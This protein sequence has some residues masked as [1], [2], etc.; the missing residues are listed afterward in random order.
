[1]VDRLLPLGVFLIALLVLALGVWIAG[2]AA[3][4]GAL[5]SVGAMI[6]A[7]GAVW[8]VSKLL[9]EHAS[10]AFQAL[11]EEPNR[12]LAELMRGPDYKSQLGFLHAV[13]EDMRSVLDLICTDRR[14]LIVFIDDLDR[15]SP[16]V[17]AEVIQAINL[18]VA[19]TFPN[20]IFVVAMEPAVV[21]AHLESVYAELVERFA[22]DNSEPLGWLFLEKIVQLP[23][24]LPG[25]RELPQIRTYIN[26]L[27]SQEKTASEGPDAALVS[28]AGSGSGDAKPR[29]F[30]QVTPSEHVTDRK[31]EEIVGLIR[32]VNPA[33]GQIL[34]EAARIQHEVL[35]TVP[36]GT[37]HPLAAAAARRVFI[38]MFSDERQ[39]IQEV[40]MSG[41]NRLERATPR[42]IKR[43]IN[44]FRFFAFVAAEREFGGDRAVTLEQTAKLAALAIRWP[45]VMDFLGRS[46]PD[47]QLWLAKLERVSTLSNDPKN[48]VDP[49]WEYILKE[50]PWKG[51]EDVLKNIHRFLRADDI[52]LGEAARGLA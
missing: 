7:I 12:G 51:N 49:E 25:N 37:L 14:P 4:A 48:I 28:S 43:Y 20:S 47:G 10:L 1:V 6:A 46:A 24:T 41:V 11:L 16:G 8:R 33:V 52:K 22:H 3:V 2:A 18:F 9:R 35:P 23:F 30:D 45:H 38:E 50:L 34:R 32:N 26:S 21:A 36:S 5:A 13:Q 19:G 27:V 17:V 15:C 44:L 29:D 42:Q 39:E 31:V 40:M